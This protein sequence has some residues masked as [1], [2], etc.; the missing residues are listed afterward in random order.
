MVKTV[1]GGA[2]RSSN[3]KSGWAHF[4]GN[5]GV[6]KVPG[7]ETYS[8]TRPIF[9]NLDALEAGRRGLVVDTNGF[10]PMMK[11]GVSNLPGE[12]GC[13]VKRGMGSLTVYPVT[14]WTVTGRNPRP[15]LC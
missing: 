1:Y 15:Y 8:F 11:Q 12:N 6:Y 13:F 9:Y 2:G 7:I 5:G 4:V 10:D 14:P 3:G